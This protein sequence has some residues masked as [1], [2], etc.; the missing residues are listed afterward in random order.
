MTSYLKVTGSYEDID[1]LF[2]NSHFL[3]VR[4]FNNIGGNRWDVTIR[5]SENP[6]VAEAISKAKTVKRLKEIDTSRAF[7]N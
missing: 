6:E 2:E 1:D 5:H 7:K 4:Y 3:S